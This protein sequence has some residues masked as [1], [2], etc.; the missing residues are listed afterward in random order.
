MSLLQYWPVAEEINACIKHEAEGAHDALL[1]AVHRPSPL[2]Y[3]LISS[4]EKFDASEEDLFKYLISGDVPSGAHVVP[5]T[6][7]S[8][9]G[10][11]HMVRILNARLQSINEDGRYV[12]IRIPKS[13]SLRKVVELILEKLPEDEYVQV[14]AEF[15]KVLTEDLNVETA[16][17]RFQR[18]LDITLGQLAKELETRV[19]ANPRDSV[20]KEQLGHAGALSKFMGDP[21]LVDH[22]RGKIFPRFVQRAIVGQHQVESVELIRDFVPDDLV[23]PESIDLSKSAF[24]TNAYYTRNLLGRDGEGLRAATRLL[25]ENM[26]ADQAIRQLFNLHQSLGGMTIQEVILE[27]RRRLLGQGRELVIFVEDFKALTGIQDILLKVLIQEGVRDGVQE[28]ATMRSVIAVT[29]GYL[30]TEDTIA[31]RAKREWKVESELS[32]PAEVLSRTKALIAAYLNASRWGFKELLRHFETNREGASQTER[33]GVYADPDGV[34]DSP[35]LA[36]FGYDEGIPLFPYTELAI[37]QL[38][39]AAL[40]R[41]NALVF[42]PRFIIDNVLRSLL[43]LGRPAFE[44]GLFPPPGISAPVTTAEVAQ[45]VAS[46]P[47]SA[48]L[49]ERYRRV[50]SIWGNAPRNMAEVGYIPKEVFDAFNLKRPAIDFHPAP[51]AETKADPVKAPPQWA[52]QPKPD[53]GSLKEIL[54]KWAQGER[55][56]QIAANHIRKSVAAA[57]N[58]RI[59]WSGERCAKAPILPTQISIP[60]AGGEA[61]LAANPIKV[62]EDH[63]DL[64]GHLRSELAAV[65]RLYHLNAGKRSYEDADDDMVWVGNLADRLM[66]QAVSLFRAV[67]HQKLGAAARLLQTN[68]Q[69]LG[70]SLRGMTPASIALFLFGEPDAPPG[71]LVGANAAFVEWRARQEQAVRVRTDLMQLVASY[72]GSFQGSTGKI[73]YAIDTVRVMSALQAESGTQGANVLELP[74]ELRATLIELGETRVSPLARR[75]LQEATSIRNKLVAEFGESFDKHE[76]VDELKALADQLGGSGAW[77][78]QDIGIGTAAFK[79]RCDDFRAAAVG[80]ALATLADVGKEKMEQGSPHLITKMGRLEVNPLIIAV[81]FVDLARKV[82]RAAERHA[83]ALETQ[84]EGVDPQA[85]AAEIQDLLRILL[86]E[87]DS[88]SV[89][90]EAL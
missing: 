89:E 73:A 33:I 1:L 77:P 86:D 82:V 83:S 87:L 78:M 10:K 30:D 52:P 8:G 65:T 85:Q 6:G 14:R 75:A 12:V 43:L 51:E 17:I 44:K 69:M 70:L 7:R 5:I 4:G 88:F 40:T 66:P 45:W 32:S 16:V 34:G 42:T 15:A 2:S 28:L 47:V 13:A 18:E 59:D 57:L 35:V 67:T 49:Q 24:Q 80:T 39:R 31:T 22:F 72:C 20:L 36:A 55:M 38:A 84:F 25:N 60:N 41:N 58:D 46:L 53:D 81:E 62:S 71:A 54:E 21:V 9:V 37:E 79:N 3:K 56:P 29:D 26:V 19:R 27:I 74:T 11:S 68:S 50:V 76:I 63:A 61:G 23:L 90:G 48:E 64:S